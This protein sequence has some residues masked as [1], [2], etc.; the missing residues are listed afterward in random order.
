MIFPRALN[1]MLT[2]SFA[3]ASAPYGMLLARFREVEFAPAAC[4]AVVEEVLA[5]TPALAAIFDP[6]AIGRGELGIR[7]E[8]RTPALDG[9]R[10][11]FQRGE[12]GFAITIGHE[13]LEGIADLIRLGVQGDDVDEFRYFAEA[14]GEDTLRFIIGED[15]PPP[16]RWP[17][18]GRPGVHRREHASVLIRS[19]TTTVLVDPIGLQLGLPGIQAAPLSITPEQVGAIDAIAITHG[20]SDHFHLPSL[21]AHSAPDTPVIVPQVPTTS[22]I[23][24]VPFAAVLEAMGQ[25][26]TYAPAWH[27][28]VTVGD[29]EIDV[30]PFYGEQP[31]RDAPGPAPGIRN[32]GNCYLLRTPELSVA[33]L[34]DSG[35]DPLGSMEEVG[36]ELGSKYGSIDIAMSCLRTF[37]APFF[38][39]LAHYWTTLPFARLEELWQQHRAGTLPSAT[40]GPDGVARFCKAAGVRHYLPYAHGF[41]ALRAP[42]PDIGWGAGEPSEAEAVR[43]LAAALAAHGAA[44]E[45]HAWTPGDGARVE[46]GRLVLEPSGPA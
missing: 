15:E 8:V 20:H 7:P 5:Q 18:A 42:L 26:A 31:T 23:E 32:W 12:I 37:G 29:I 28:S 13:D 38:G 35:V 19:R 27:S 36:R 40:A 39:G 16:P 1:L 46:A 3:G 6:D 45:V 44:T 21:L 41:S 24:P 30:L 34:V 33:L 11:A 43:E 14:L 9:W 22:T 2:P 25:A 17:D 4:R 10:I